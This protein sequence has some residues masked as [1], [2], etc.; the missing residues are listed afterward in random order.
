MFPL[1]LGGSDE[2][3]SCGVLIWRLLLPPKDDWP[4]HNIDTVAELLADE[5]LPPQCTS[6]CN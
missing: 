1:N 4:P 6:D 3:V 2:L 5:E